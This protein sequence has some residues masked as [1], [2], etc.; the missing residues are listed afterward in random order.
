MSM[1]T[2]QCARCDASHSDKLKASC[3]HEVELRTLTTPPEAV[4]VEG[5][6]KV[7][8]GIS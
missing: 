2:L 6:Q 3:S 1:S 8:L 7:D 5:I 4:E